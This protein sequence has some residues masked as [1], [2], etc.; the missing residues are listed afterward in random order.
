M[1]LST[2]F[3]LEEL[4]HSDTAEREGIDNSLDPLRDGEG[5]IVSNL[6]HLCM[7]ILEPVRKK[8]GKPITPNSGYRCPDLNIAVG[9]SP[10]SQHMK[11]EAV[12]IE[13]PGVSN[14]ALASHIA[15]TYEFDQLI[16]ERYE[17]DDPTAG[18]VHVSFKRQ[19]GN[20]HE[21]RTIG[22]KISQFGLPIS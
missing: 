14:L 5:T 9:G 17:E 16:L 2:H 20:R 19:G 11:G 6:Q 3:T 8:Y 21:V 1:H 10:V 4:T 7:C 18:W 13:V 22:P 12:D 15:A